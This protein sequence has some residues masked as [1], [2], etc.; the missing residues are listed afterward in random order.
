MGGAGPKCLFLPF[1]GVNCQ[2]CPGNGTLRDKD[3]AEEHDQDED[4]GSSHLDLI[5]GQSDESW[6]LT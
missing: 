4:A 5:G 2:H 6:D 1:C 3:E